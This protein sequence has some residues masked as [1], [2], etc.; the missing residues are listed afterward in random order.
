MLDRPHGVDTD[1]RNEH[2]SFL[3]P[4]RNVWRVERARRAAVLIDAAAYFEALR[5]AMREARESIVIVGWDLDSRM[6]LVGPSGKA[7]DGLPETLAAFLA[8]L[9]QRRPGLK[10]R[11]LLWDYSMVFSLERELT[12]ILSFLWKTPPQIEICLDDVLPLG[13]SHHQKIVVIDDKLAFTGGLDLTTARW[14][15]PEHQPANPLRVDTAGRP[16]GPFHDVQM[17]ID[18]AA[19]AALAELVRKRWER[20]AC[21]TLRRP[22]P[23]TGG[24]DP[25][26]EALQ[27]DFRDVD[28]GIARTMPCYAGEPAV[29]EV[30][31]LFED[32]A[33]RARRFLYVENQ[34]VT[35]VA[36]VERLARRM[37]ER[38]ELEVMIV[39]PRGY[40][41][42]VERRV[43][44]AGRLRFM[45]ILE[46]AGCIDRVRLLYPE[47]GGSTDGAPVMVHSKVMIVDD[48]ILRIGS[49]NLCNRSMGLDT[50]CD[51]VIVATD[52]D[53][54]AAIARVRN[55][56]IAEHAGL[57]VPA[58]E[59][60]IDRAID[61]GSSVFEAVGRPAASRRLRPVDDAATGIAVDDA[62]LDAVADPL[63]PIEEE[64]ATSPE[65]TRGPRFRLFLKIVLALMAAAL[66]TLVWRMSP[67]GD[68]GK[69]AQSISAIS[70][71][72]WA[73]LAVIAGFLVAESVAFPVTLLI[74]ATI[75][76]FGGWGGALLAAAGAMASAIATYFVGRW[77]GARFLR[78]FIG[79][80]I[81]RVRR[82]LSDRGVLAV[83]AVRVVPVAPFTV[84]N[85]VAG[86]IGL[87]FFDYAVGTAIGLMPGIVVMSALGHQIAS[88]FAGP[89][90]G[91]IALLACFILVWVG[92]GLGLQIVLARYR[93]S[94]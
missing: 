54:R 44:T 60:A 71:R 86:A 92:L 5:S 48:E 34:F 3:E 94:G 30:A 22:P 40:K 12:P 29:D 20:A 14:D 28:I 11:L 90:L 72:P 4:G 80:R 39:A 59:R 89:T 17:A 85:L 69:I 53:T 68:P 36:T 47:S 9:V 6:K 18:G 21:E 93:S 51:L 23:G 79:P 24:S 78:R 91:G 26:P 76:V 35:H 10:V 57:D 87:R 46:Q 81:N 73:P 58:V 70:E 49:A 61:R 41:G 8:A 45:R 31:V 75:A 19:A 64:R 63:E 74:F 84:V 67:L 25:W 62:L 7:E 37:L 1:A 66:L 42:W 43:M 15:T 33:G 52:D 32:M 77:L 88:L 65:Q 83:A 50:E 38:P 16:Y 2:A 82:G 13:A 56:L 27:P 55:R